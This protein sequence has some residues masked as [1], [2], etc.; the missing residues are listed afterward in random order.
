M[1]LTGPRQIENSIVLA[2]SIPPL[3]SGTNSLVETKRAL[4]VDPRSTIRYFNRGQA[5]YYAGQYDQAIET[6][7]QGKDLDP[8][9]AFFHL[10]LAMLYTHESKF[11]QALAEFPP[12]Q[13]PGSDLD[14]LIAYV[15]NAAG[16]RAEALERLERAKHSQP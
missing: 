14:L 16:R 7:R 5:L 8:N 6:V 9:Y 12:I 11:D 3:V 10:L 13:M 4:Q 1:I 2:S 15:L